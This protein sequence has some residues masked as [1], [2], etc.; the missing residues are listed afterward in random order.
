MTAENSRIFIFD[1]SFADY[2]QTLWEENKYGKDA[3]D[4]G[5]PGHASYLQSGGESK[6]LVRFFYG[7]G[8]FMFDQVSYQKVGRIFTC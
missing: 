2:S 4:A 6:D 7:D 8:E 3:G 5:I 1:E